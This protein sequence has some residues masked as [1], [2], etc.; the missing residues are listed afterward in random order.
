MARVAPLTPGLPG[1]A[2]LVGRGRAAPGRA[3]AGLPTDRRRGRGRRRVHGPGRRRG[4][5]PRQV[6]A[7]IVLDRDEIGARGQQ[8]QRRHGP[9]RRQARPR[10]SFWP[11]P[12]GRRALGRD[13]GRLRGRRALGARARDRLRL[14]AHGDT[15]SWPIIPAR[16]R[17]Q[18]ALADAYA[19]DRRGGPVPRAAAMLGS[20]IGRGRFFGG[21]LVE[22]SAGST[23]P[24]W[25]P[26]WPVPPWRPGP[27]LHGR[28]RP[29]WPWSGGDRSTSSTRSR[30]TMRC[31]EVVVATNGTTDRRLV[32]VA[33]PAR[34]PHRE[35]HDRHRAARS[36]ALAP[37]VN[38]HGRMFFDTRNLLHYWRL[39][40]D[41]TAGPLR[42]SDVARARPPSRGPGTCCTAPWC[43]SIRSWPGVRV[44]RA[45]GGHV[46]AHGRPLSPR[47]TSP[48]TPASST[49]WATAG[50]GW[51]LSVH[52]GRAV[53][54]W[55]CGRGDLPAL[56]RPALAAVPRPA[57]VP[58]APGRW[59]AWGSRCRDALGR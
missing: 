42:G 49:P 7:V 41:G 50:A 36:G 53:G 23:P 26:D 24:S 58:V 15:W 57:H 19:L 17:H 33:R 48:A 45:W 12:S 4:R 51:R 46:G 14:A 52:F 34:P 30:G 29:C 2:L 6:G 3:G 54:R 27:M 47:G 44:A 25:R 20:E 13:R 1:P 9:P 31:G 8:S 37:S 55:L 39:S 5:S 16:G 56:R 35:L 43:R 59:R 40:P 32:A 11:Q 38:P 22:R 21:L 18:R 28:D 10:R